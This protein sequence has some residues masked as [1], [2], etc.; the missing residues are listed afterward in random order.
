MT[1]TSPA[2][3]SAADMSVAELSHDMPRSTTFDL[4]WSSCVGTALANTC[5]EKFFEPFA[6]CF[7]PEGK[8]TGGAMSIFHVTWDSGAVFYRPSGVIP[9]YGPIGWANG[10]KQCLKLFPAGT[11][12]GESQISDEEIYCDPTDT[13]CLSYDGGT[14]VSNG[15]RYNVNTGVFTCPDGETVKISGGLSSCPLLSEL[16]DPVTAFCPNGF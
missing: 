7:V 9:V 10:Q 11:R 14:P 15:L 5:V 6:A 12:D 2:D 16:L 13:Q 4:A 3:M 8:C 1:A